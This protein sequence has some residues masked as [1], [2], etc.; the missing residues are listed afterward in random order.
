[1]IKNGAIMSGATPDNDKV[2]LCGNMDFNLDIK[3]MLESNGWSEGTK[4]EQ[5]SYVLEKAFVG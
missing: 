2:M 5:G 3:E 1:L 4:R